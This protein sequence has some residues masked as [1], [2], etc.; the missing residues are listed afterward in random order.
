[1]THIKFGI[2][3]VE[4]QNHLFPG[5]LLLI[6]DYSDANLNPNKVKPIKL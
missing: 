3:A 4:G 6:F 2:G 5:V 1:M